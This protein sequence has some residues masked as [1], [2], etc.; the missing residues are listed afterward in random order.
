M[1]PVK[2]REA[3]TPESGSITL[4]SGTFTFEKSYYQASR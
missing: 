1:L 3:T 2:E 4:C